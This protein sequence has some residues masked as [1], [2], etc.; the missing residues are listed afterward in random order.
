MSVSRDAVGDFLPVSRDAVGDFLAVRRDAV[1]DCLAI[2]RDAVGGLT[3]VGEFGSFLGPSGVAVNVFWEMRQVKSR[4]MY[5][6][7]IKEATV[8]I[9]GT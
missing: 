3:C 8:L 6:K 9:H 4:T 5:I 2:S 7:K 1:G